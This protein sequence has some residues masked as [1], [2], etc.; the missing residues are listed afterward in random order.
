[1]YPQKNSTHIGLMEYGLVYHMPKMWFNIGP[2]NGLLP[3][4]TKPLPETMLTFPMLG[5]VV[6]T[7]EQFY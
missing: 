4:G 1:M 6:F 7:Q 2:V 5:S 3:D